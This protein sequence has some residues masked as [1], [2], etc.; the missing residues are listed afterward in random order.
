MKAIII[1][2]FIIFAILL[3]NA[4]I[5]GQG[6][7][8]VYRGVSNYIQTIAIE[9]DYVW[10]GTRNGVIRWNRLDGTNTLYNVDDGLSYHHVNDVMV[11]SKG[12]KWFGTTWWLTKF[13]GNSW[14]Q[15]DEGLVYPSIKSIAEDLDGVIWVGT[16]WG[17]TSI[18]GTIMQTYTTEDGLAHRAVFSIA[19]DHDNVK[20]FGTPGGV[21]SFDGNTWHTYT[22]K[23][24]LIHDQVWDIEIDANNVKWFGCA[25]DN[26]DNNLGGITRYDDTTWLSYTTD[27]GLP[28]N[29]VMSLTIDRENIVWVGTIDGLASFDGTVFRTWKVYDQS[30]DR[31]EKI[32]CIEVDENNIK[33]IGT[34]SGLYSFDNQ[35]WSEYINDYGLVSGWVTSLAIDYDNVKWFGTEIGVS[36]FDDVMW[37]TYTEK[38]GLASDTITCIAVDHNNIKWFGTEDCGVTAFTNREWITYTTENSGIT[39]NHINFIEVDKKNVQW[40]STNNGMVCFNGSQW[41]TIED[42]SGNKLDAEEMAIDSQN[43]KW[44]RHNNDLLRYDGNDWKIY[45]KNN[46]GFPGDAIRTIAIDRDD[47]LWVGYIVENDPFSSGYC[48]FDGVKW[49]LYTMDD[50]LIYFKPKT[51]AVDN[52]NIKWFGTTRGISA[53]DGDSWISYDDTNVPFLRSVYDIT[54][55]HNNTIWITVSGGKV[56]AYQDGV[57]K[58]S[59]NEFITS[60]KST[61]LSPFESVLLSNTPNPFNTATTITFTLPSPTSV[62]LEI[63][64]I[65]GQRI[66]TIVNEYP[67]TGIH[68]VIWDGTDKS[69]NKASSGIYIYRLH[70]GEFTKSN[71]MMLLR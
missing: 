70:A 69:G 1:K 26:G 48:S 59:A 5:Y 44:F 23:D 21:S 58:T 54:V 14:K 66:N 60:V 17:V 4:V 63:Y 19:V 30:W 20:W 16:D 39:S 24:G 31:Y 57:W 43:N 7:Y 8:P 49:T 12:N 56:I 42:P 36:S 71:K 27:D 28:N 64:N 45:N 41:S 25:F 10:C 46:S 67:G 35:S 61:S 50:G 15:Y 37:Q 18:N 62:V 47:I 22:S 9:G 40:I 32:H 38:D 53:F 29:F 33:W 3:Y 55:D 65:A 52:F 13:D 34:D 2:I 6:E 68:S 11:D 51:V